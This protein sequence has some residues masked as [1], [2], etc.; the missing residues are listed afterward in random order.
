MRAPPA[1]HLLYRKAD[2]PGEAD[3]LSLI[4]GV[5]I[6]PDRV[7][8]LV[9]KYFGAVLSFLRSIFIVRRKKRVYNHFS[10]HVRL[11]Q[12]NFESKNMRPHNPIERRESA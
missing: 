11:A 1:K 12:V 9:T 8:H 2:H 10:T 4:Y 7:T 5:M 6:D 3:R